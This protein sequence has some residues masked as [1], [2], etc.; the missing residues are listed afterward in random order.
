MLKIIE[1]NTVSDGYNI[2]LDNNI[3]LHMTHQNPTIDQ[4]NDLLIGFE[5][6]KLGEI[7]DI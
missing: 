7:D 2:I 1:Q 4:I 5:R 6:Q 3:V